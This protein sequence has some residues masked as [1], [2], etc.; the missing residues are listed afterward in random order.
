MALFRRV[1]MRARLVAFATA[2]TLVVLS[3]GAVVLYQGVTSE[4]SDAI[5][6]ELAIRA[7]DLAASTDNGTASPGSPIVT[8]QKLDP[9]GTVLFPRGSTP[10]LTDPELTRAKQGRVVVDREIPLIGEHAR[11]LAGPYPSAN[12]DIVVVAATTTAPLAR[13]SELLLLVLAVGGPVLALAA[14][15]AVWFLT[16]AAVRP[17]RRMASEAATIS[18]AHVGRR[19]PLPPA[20]DEL[21]DLGRTLNAML[22]RIETAITHERAFIDDAAHELRTPIAIIR[23][24]LELAMHERDDPDVVAQNLTSALEETDRLAYLTDSLLTLA[25]ADAGELVIGN[26]TTELLATASACVRRLP[27]RDEISVEVQGEPVEVRGDPEWISHVVS[28]LVTNA[29]R[30]AR[31]RVLVTVADAAEFGELVVADDGPGF[32]AAL[33]PRAFDRFSRADTERGG[34]SGGAGL[35]LAIVAT[36]ARAAGGD[37]DASNGPPLGGARVQVRLALAGDASHPSLIGD[38]PA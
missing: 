20:D 27:R 10:L 21:A 35:G 32:P 33:L 2:G 8:A 30:H 6:D 11:L 5:T 25:R 28:N 13:A 24:E 29:Q 14:G 7:A 38:G 9:D 23:G 16:G 15:V 37:V 12:G 18:V 4:L 34:V 36:L 1:P 3:T 17:M 31:T 22:E 26:A 19:L